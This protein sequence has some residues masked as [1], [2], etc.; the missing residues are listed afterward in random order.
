MAPTAST[1][2]T[3]T[4]SNRPEDINPNHTPPGTSHPRHLRTDRSARA[5]PVLA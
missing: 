3:S 1:T 4:V 5:F 2:I